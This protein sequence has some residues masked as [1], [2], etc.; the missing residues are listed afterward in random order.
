MPLSRRQ[1]T[2]S[3]L[4]GAAALTAACATRA[5]ETPDSTITPP[6]NR[7]AV[8]TYSFWRFLENS[9]LSIDQCIDEAARMGFDGVE[10][11]HMQMESEA[12]AYL[13]RLKQRAFVNGLDLCGFST[14]QDFVTPDEE[15]RQQNVDHTIRCIELAYALGIPTIRVNTGRWGTTKD[16][17]TLMAN[18]GIEPNLEGYTDDD[19]F[20]WV[21]DSFERCV[22]V[23]E[24]CG[25]T[26]GLENHWGLGRTPEGVLRIIDAVDSPWLQATLDTGNFLE[27]PYDRLE[28]MAPRAVLVQAK[29]YYGGG[30][31]YALELDYPRIAELLRRHNYRGYVSLEYEG[32][33][34][35]RTAIPRSLERLREAFG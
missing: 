30:I 15:E 29:T 32:K 3:I 31:W 35:W 1:F 28:L 13:Q 17:D 26:M 23:A 6:R 18:R 25:V 34:D 21:I 20:A 7:I 2:T 33:E 27:D 8:S 9:K 16:F 19:G 11:L 24:R 14:H 12:P 4:G 22:P 5:Q 10:I